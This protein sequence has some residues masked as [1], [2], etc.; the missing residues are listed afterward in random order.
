MSEYAYRSLAFA[1]KIKGLPPFWPDCLIAADRSDTKVVENIRSLEVGDLIWYTHQ[2][3][4]D[5]ATYLGDEMALGLNHEGTPVIQWWRVWKIG[6]A[7][8][9]TS[10][11]IDMESRE[12]VQ[13]TQESGRVTA[14]DTASG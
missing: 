9:L 10:K 1:R 14:E 11:T 13:D 12:N 6:E 3:H 5:V 4:G 8:V 7:P 2:P